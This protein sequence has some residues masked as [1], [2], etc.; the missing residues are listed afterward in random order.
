MDKELTYE[1]I[2]HGLIAGKQYVLKKTLQWQWKMFKNNDM[3]Y[4]VPGTSDEIHMSAFGEYFAWT[5]YGSSANDATMDGLKFIIDTIFKA[6]PSDFTEMSA[7][8]LVDVIN[9]GR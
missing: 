8:A 7:S 4:F 5:H 9:E 3:R 6:D 1:D 2:F